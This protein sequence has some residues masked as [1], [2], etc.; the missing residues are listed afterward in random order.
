MKLDLQP[1]LV[2]PIRSW[3]RRDPDAAAITVEGTTYSRADLDALSD[4]IGGDLIRR[5]V[6]V[7]DRVGIMGSICAEWCFTALAVLKIGAVI[8]PMTE[9]LSSTEVAAVLARVGAVVA[10]SDD[11]HSGVIADAV[12]AADLGAIVETTTF[13]EVLG[14]GPPDRDV[15]RQPTG[16]QLAAVVFT[17]GSTGLPKG[18]MLTH[19]ALMNAIFESVLL[20]PG[21]LRCRALDVTSLAY[22]GGLLNAFLGPQVLGGS[23]VLLPAWDP[24]HALELIER[25]AI[26]S[27]ACTTIFYEQ[28]AESARFADT[29]LSTITVAIA[30]G[31][32]VPVELLERWHARGV[33]IRQGYGLTEGCSLVTLPPADVAMDRPDIAGVGGILRDVTVVD[34]DDAPVPAGTPGQ[35]VIRGPGI[36]TGY[37]DDP[38]TTAAEFAGGLLH[39]GDVGTIDETG[40]LRIV[41]R[42]KDVIISG[43][44]NIY[45]AE[46]E[47]VIGEIAGVLEVAVIGVADEQYGETPAALV[48]ASEHLAAADVVDHCRNRLATYKAPRYVEFLDDKLPRTPIGKVAKPELRAAFADLPDRGRRIAS[49]R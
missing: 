18:S 20:E 33:S 16:E 21:L 35:I 46:L 40:G 13:G 19:S 9:R 3:C 30:G 49:S 28:M 34:D 5:G 25:E 2:T 41:G 10:V 42:T 1:D 8:V 37:W 44:I 4:A 24:A 17:S 11:D 12:A 31:S 29:D 48:V 43:G 36:S 7:G 22:L 27:T 38:E 45:A 14:A 32:A 23:T 26:T 15:V 47:R 6:E 39:T